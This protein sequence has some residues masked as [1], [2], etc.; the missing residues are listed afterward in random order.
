MKAIWLLILVCLGALFAGCGGGGS[1]V[2]PVNYT[3]SGR[4][5]WIESGAAPSPVASVRAGTVSVSTDASDG[6]F[7]LLVP[8]GT[9]ALEVTFTRTGQPPIVRSFPL[10]TLTGATDVGDL[11]IGPEVVTVTGVVQSSSNNNPVSNALAKIGGLSA[12]TDVN[13]RFTISGVAYS[14]AGLPVFT[15]LQGEVTATGFFIG[16]FNPPSGPVGGTVDVG[17]VRI[18][19]TGGGDPPPFP[20]NIVG[21]VLPASAGGSAQVR[22]LQGASVI[23]TT[24]ADPNGNFGFWVPAGTYTLEATAGPRIGTTSV[25]LPNVNQVVTANVTLP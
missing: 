3:V 16:L 11:Y 9:P 17:V 14:P 1:T 19:P 4:V 13:G 21:Q 6:F 25:T 10:P 5:L 18:T 2:P 23:R 12:V 24:T 8:A 15:G 20:N 22:L 7:Q